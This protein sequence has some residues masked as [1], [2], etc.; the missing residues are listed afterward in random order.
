VMKVDNT[1]VPGYLGAARVLLAQGE[2]DSVLAICERAEAIESGYA[3][4]V[5]DIKANAYLKL[6]RHQAAIAA[7]EAAIEADPSLPG[8]R[9]NL[10]KI[11]A[12]QGRKDDAE[13]VLREL[14]ARNP[15]HPQARQL[16]QSLRSN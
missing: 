11:L 15:D 6:D 7:C 13:R 1:Y 9:L 14:L 12:Y 4:Y 3:A 10:A 8:P 16:L 2:Y 5:Y